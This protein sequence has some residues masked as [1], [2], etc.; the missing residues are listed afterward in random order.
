M[1]RIFLDYNST[2]PL[3]TSVLEEMLPFFESKFGNP[4]SLHF[5]GRETAAA[6]DLAR[7][8]AGKLIGANVD[9]IIFTSGGTESNNLAL[10]GIAG[11]LKDKRNHIITSLVEHSSVY[12]QCVRLEGEGVKVTYLPVNR[13]GEVS[14]SDIEQAVTEHTSLI[15]LI[16]ANNE[17]GTILDTAG[18]SQIARKA[19]ALLHYDAVQAVGK[20]PVDVSKLGADLLSFSGHKIYGPKGSGVLFLRRGIALQSVFIG[21]EQENARRPGTHNVPAIAGLGKAC[22]LAGTELD[23]YSRHCAAMRDRLQSGVMKLPGAMLNGCPERRIPNTLN[24]SFPGHY[25]SGMAVK[26]DLAGIAVST[27]SAC[28]AG[29]NEESRVLKSMGLSSSELLGALRFSVGRHTTEK[30]VDYAIQKLAEI[31]STEN[32]IG[33]KLNIVNLDKL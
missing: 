11:R 10:S 15:S 7:C 2:T 12:E 20:I 33:R 17:T 23:E 18:V 19:G 31:V 29:R 30:E 3:H 16:L 24:V 21:G 1:R 27:G 8:R 9:E 14:L 26:L 25:G 22:E 4:S 6:L 28:S 5:F 13:Q 32:S